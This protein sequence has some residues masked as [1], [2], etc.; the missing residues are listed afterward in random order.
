MTDA[1]FSNGFAFAKY[2]RGKYSYTDNRGGTDAHFFAYMVQGS[3]R[4]ITEKEDV[5]IK[6]GDFF[7]I[8][9]DCAYQSVWEDER[10][11]VFYSLRFLCLPVFNRQSYPCQAI[12]FDEEAYS[13]L[14]KINFS[15][16]LCAKDIGYFYT[17]AARLLL[18]MRA[19]PKSK[20]EEIMD[21]VTLLLHEDPHASPA[22]LAEK[23]HICESSL[24]RIFAQN[25]RSLLGVRQNVILEKAK[26]L[27]ITTDKSIEDISAS[28]GFSSSSYFRKLFKKKFSLTPRALRKS[29]GI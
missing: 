11:V 5:Y 24:Y 22:L 9:K 13:S 8:P 29:Q 19:I 10:E 7:Y 15:S 27:L 3:C 4:I 6:A 12:P 20:G 26:T 14:Q 16:R 23:C 18:F 1:I 17:L 2:K 25:N 28:L 21:I